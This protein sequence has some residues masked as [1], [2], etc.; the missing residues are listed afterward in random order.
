MAAQVEK[1]NFVGARPVLEH[2]TFRDKF[3]IKQRAVGSEP[4]RPIFDLNIDH[5]VA[6]ALETRRIGYY[7]DIDISPC[8][9]VD[10]AELAQLVAFTEALTTKYDLRPNWATKAWRDA[11][12]TFLL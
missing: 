11:K 1:S 10:E 9:R 3:A 6:Q 7:V 5:V 2:T 8:K 4:E 12:V